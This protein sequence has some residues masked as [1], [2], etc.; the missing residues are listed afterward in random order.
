MRTREAKYGDVGR[1]FK[2]LSDQ[3][4]STGWGSIPIN[5]KTLRT[6][7]V[8]LIRTQDI[9]DVLIAEEDGEVKGVMLV[10]MDNFFWAKEPYASDV[11]FI[12]T[13]GGVAL[14]NKF[15]DWAQ[16]RKCKCIVMAVATDDPRAELFLK[17]SGFERRGGA[18]VCWL[19]KPAQE[20]AA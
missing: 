5:P 19:D 20:I 13:G 15:K 3:H 16:R 4:E 18:L 14:L 1:V 9:C 7:I 11:H 6:A 12:A 8:S 10:Q 17:A 2:Y